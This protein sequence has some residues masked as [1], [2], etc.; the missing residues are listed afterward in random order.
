MG[1]KGRSGIIGFD[2]VC[3]SE[4][5]GTGIIFTDER[6]CPSA[7]FVQREE[8]SK[9]DFFFLSVIAGARTVPLTMQ[10]HAMLARLARYSV[11]VVYHKHR[12]YTNQ[13]V[14]WG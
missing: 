5:D 13:L 10:I 8:L 11:M 9:L 6:A 1:S 4:Q 2:Y 7:K 14:W 12:L 3:M